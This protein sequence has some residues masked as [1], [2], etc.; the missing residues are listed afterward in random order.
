VGQPEMLRVPIRLDGQGKVMALAKEVP[1]LYGEKPALVTLQPVSRLWVGAAQPPDFSGT[2]PPSYQPFFL[3]LETTAADYCATL[4]KPER[5]EEFEHLYR[6]LRRRPDGHDPN[7]LFSYMQA[8]ARL[9]LSLR[10]VSQAEFEAV[11]NR[12]GRSAKTFRTHVDSTN[13]WQRVLRTLV[14]S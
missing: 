1:V 7:P 3:L 11:V 10:D 5:D 8:A 14:A 9:Y 13:Y 12:L 4:G 2:P 6:Q